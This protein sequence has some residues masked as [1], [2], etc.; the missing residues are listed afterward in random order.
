MIETQNMHSF[1]EDLTDIVDVDKQDDIQTI[2]I[3]HNKIFNAMLLTIPAGHTLKE[4]VSPRTI[5]LQILSGSG[6][7]I[8][9]SNTY[10]VRSGSW[11]YIKP[12]T[13]HELTSGD[14]TLVVLLN[15]FTCSNAESMSN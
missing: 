10:F 15:L 8:V 12:H 6:Q 1:C 3:F 7:V 11:F 14:E 13:L 9:D 2:S 5:T 4:H